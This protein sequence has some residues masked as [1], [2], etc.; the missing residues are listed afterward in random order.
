MQI[1]RPEGNP[2][3]LHDDKESLDELYSHIHF[4][5]NVNSYSI[6]FSERRK[7]LAEHVLDVLRREYNLE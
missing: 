7:K 1:T 6:Q 2:K 3:L 4:L 5:K